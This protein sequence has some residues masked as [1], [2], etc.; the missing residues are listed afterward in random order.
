LELIS[1]KNSLFI[2]FRYK[3]YRGETRFSDRK[4]KL[5]RSEAIAKYIP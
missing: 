2:K 5:G 4:E 1:K 3:I